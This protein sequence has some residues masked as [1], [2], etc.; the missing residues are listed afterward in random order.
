MPPKN[1]WRTLD[2]RAV[3]EN[4]WIKVREDRVIRPDGQ[5]GIYGVVET[6]IATGVVALT[7]DHHVYL[8]GQ[9][10]YPFDAYSWE[11]VEGGAEVGEDPADAIRRELR[12]E[13]GLI[14]N[15]WRPLGGEIHLSN[16]FTSE[17]ALLYVAQ[18]LTEVDAEPDGTEALEVMKVPFQEALDQVHAGKITDAMSV[19]A[20]MRVRDL[21]DT[22]EL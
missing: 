9:W 6:R 3:Y 18:D 2:R 4:P 15:Q 21:I 20:L 16:C 13:A 22:G 5:E 7:P 14:A 17:R 10:R 8:V 19:V 12:E 11:I 1:P